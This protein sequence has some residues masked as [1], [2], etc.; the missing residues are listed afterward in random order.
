MQKKRLSRRDFLRLGG[1]T[2]AGVVLAGCGPTTTPTPETIIQTQIVKET[3]IVT[4]KEVVKETVE[5]P[6]A[7]A[8]T[9]PITL[10]LWHHWGGDREPLLVKAC[11]DFSARN[12][13][14]SVELTL[15][16]W[17]RK[18]ETLLTAIAAGNAPDVLH[19]ISTETPVYVMDGVLVP[20]DD[21]IAT[22]GII[23]DEVV[24][25]DWQ[26]GIINGKIWALPLNSSGADLIMFTNLKFYEEDGLDPAKP[27]ATW[28]E[29]RDFAKKMTKTEN[30][31]ITRL[32]AQIGASGWEWLYYIAQNDGQWLSADGRK[33]LM[34]NPQSVEALQ[35]VVDI[36]DIQGG[37]E[38]VTA[39]LG[40]ARQT[41][42]FIADVVANYCSG[43]WVN[44]YILTGNPALR[45]GTAVAPKN[46]GPW[47][48]ESYGPQ[49][50][51]IPTGNKHNDLSFALALWLSRGDGG[52]TFL[53]PQIMPSAWNACNQ[54]NSYA[55]VAD[56]WP[57]IEA[58]FATTRPTVPTPVFNQFLS[59]WDEMMQKALLKDSTPAEAVKWA[60][61]E[62]VKTN[63][64]YWA[65]HSG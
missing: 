10:T 49:Q 24:S 2:T 47:T 46:K 11:D 57:T 37:W 50:W 56:F 58:A 8:T 63:D 60:T 9:E 61:D 44:Y 15:I 4:E 18:E 48:A 5:V 21:Y 16:P 40:I 14:V 59:I 26:S 42:P 28:D 25:V 55:L 1:L 7:A 22:A 41:E 38:K 13:G 3:E 29:M 52:C 64:E 62:M 6:V 51:T 45:Y 23:A 12:P 20:L 39:F 31:E 65:K 19:L 43:Q 35:Y 33:V 54:R 32:G 34:D 30:G 17:E 36:F 27:P 53:T